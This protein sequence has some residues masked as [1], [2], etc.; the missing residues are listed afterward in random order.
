MAEDKY[1]AGKVAIVT[2]ASKISGIGAAAAIALAEH[3]AN[4]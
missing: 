2:G 4:V 3:G 1:L